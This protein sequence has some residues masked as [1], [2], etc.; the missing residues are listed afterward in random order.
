MTV[1]DIC[2]KPNGVRK[3]N[4]MKQ[5]FKNGAALHNTIEMCE[6]CTNELQIALFKFFDSKQFKVDKPIG[7]VV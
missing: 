4:V 1:C 3:V 5:V 2:R 7:S 6:M